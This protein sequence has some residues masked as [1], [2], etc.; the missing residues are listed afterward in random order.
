MRYPTSP[1]VND[2][3]HHRLTLIVYAEDKAD[4]REMLSNS[5]HDAQISLIA[6]EEHAL[7]FP[8][9]KW[10]ICNDF[11]GTLASAMTLMQELGEY[12]KALPVVLI[13]LETLG[14][15]SRSLELSAPVLS[16]PPPSM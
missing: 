13:R 11:R 7:G 10:M 15:I 6:P 5:A 1:G 12:L 2:W 14:K 8:A 9:L 4:A 3:L 16:D